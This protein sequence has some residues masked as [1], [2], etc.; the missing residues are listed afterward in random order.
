LAIESPSGKKRFTARNTFEN[1]LETLESACPE[2][3]ALDGVHQEQHVL[4]IAQFAQAQ[5]VFRRRGGDTP[6]TLNAL[7][8]DGNRCGRNRF[9]HGGEIVERHVAKALDHRLES[10]LHLFLTRRGD[11]G[12]RA[13]VE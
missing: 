1:P 10:F 4:F 6:F 5:Q 11:S 9:A 12:E 2:V 8:K 13:A 7:D 3:A